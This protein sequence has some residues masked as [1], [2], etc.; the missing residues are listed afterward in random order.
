[1]NKTNPGLVVLEERS[2][3][4]WTLS[5]CR[6]MAKLYYASV[7]LGMTGNTCCAFLFFPV[8]RTSSL[9]PLIGLTSESSIRYHVWLGHI[10][11]LFF[12]AHGICYVVLWTA[13]G[14][15]WQVYYLLA[16]YIWE[17]LSLE[18]IVLTDCIAVAEMGFS[19]NIKRGWRNSI[20]LWVIDVGDY[21]PSNQTQHVWALLLHSSALLP[22]PSLLSTSPGN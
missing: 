11:M 22:F 3:E 16:I 2:N 20:A 12:T 13:M 6:W 7:W 19:S 21:V 1:M 15:L 9:L 14:D 8:T 17:L 5:S 10:A 18:Y 4:T